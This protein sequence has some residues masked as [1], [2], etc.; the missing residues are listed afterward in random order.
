[1]PSASKR[2]P[3]LALRHAIGQPQQEAEAVG[4]LRRAE[5]DLRRCSVLSCERQIVEPLGSMV[6]CA[7]RGPF[8]SLPAWGSSSN[9]SVLY[10]ASSRQNSQRP[11]NAYEAYIIRP[12]TSIAGLRPESGRSRHG[13]HHIPERL[14]PVTGKVADKGDRIHG[15]GAPRPRADAAQ[16]AFPGLVGAGSQ[17]KAR[18]RST[19]RLT[20]LPSVH[21]DFVEGDGGRDRRHA[22]AGRGST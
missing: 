17:R 6:R 10:A 1:M 16:A 12:S 3:K 9:R 13:C 4:E 14:N 15:R 2:W 7:S 5:P 22:K 21:D 19:R 8:S 11:L 20:S 18:A